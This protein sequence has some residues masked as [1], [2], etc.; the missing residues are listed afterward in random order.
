[1][2]T[3]LEPYN[4]AQHRTKKPRSMQKLHY[5]IS[6]P[7]IIWTSKKEIKWEVI[8]KNCKGNPHWFGA[9]IEM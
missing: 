2:A 6:K 7:V 3:K 8:D 1:M 5:L 9:F 4:F